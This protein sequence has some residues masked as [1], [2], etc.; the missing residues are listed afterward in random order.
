MQ[1]NNDLWMQLVV[2]YTCVVYHSITDKDDVMA[3]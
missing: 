3:E 2:Q 1:M